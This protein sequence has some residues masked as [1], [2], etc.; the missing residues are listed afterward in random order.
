MVISS[1]GEKASTLLTVKKNIEREI[2][3]QQ[4]YFAHY[5]YEEIYICIDQVADPVI[6]CTTCIISAALS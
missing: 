2:D 5:S 6:R 3:N 1:D 4:F